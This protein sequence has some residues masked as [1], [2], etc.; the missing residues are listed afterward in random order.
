MK[1]YTERCLF[2]GRDVSTKPRTVYAGVQSLQKFRHDRNAPE[3]SRN[4]KG[5]SLQ[6]CL[7]PAKCLSGLQTPVSCDCI[8]LELV[9]GWFGPCI[10][11]L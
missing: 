1:Q 10:L 11:C 4:E 7:Y 9:L 6:L 2:L 3:Q 8:F 5:T